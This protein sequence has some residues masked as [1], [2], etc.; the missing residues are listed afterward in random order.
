MTGSSVRLRAWISGFRWLHEKARLGTLAAGE[1]EAYREAREDLAAMLVAAQRLT[2]GEGETARGAVR[3]VR[4]VPFELR[5]AAGTVRG[6]ILDLSEGGFS[7][8]LAPAPA[9]GEA[10]AV[11]LQLGS[12]ELKGLARVI[13]VIDQDVEFRVS[14]RLEELSAEALARLRSE[15]LDAALERLADLIE[16]T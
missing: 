2:L 3:V 10:V 16:R 7:A 8:M 11:T 4:S 15:I 12:G 14:F 5:A 13:S 9:H 1:D 6:R